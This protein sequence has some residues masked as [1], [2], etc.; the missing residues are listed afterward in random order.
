MSSVAAP[1]LPPLVDHRQNGGQFRSTFSYR[2]WGIISDSSLENVAWILISV[3]LGFHQKATQSFFCCFNNSAGHVCMLVYVS[4]G[5]VKLIIESHSQ[6][7]KC[8][9]ISF[10]FISIWRP[11]NETKDIFL[12]NF[13]LH[14]S[15]SH[16]M[17]DITL[18]QPGKDDHVGTRWQRSR[19]IR[20]MITHDWSPLALAFW[21][22]KIRFMEWPK[23]TRD[24]PNTWISSV[25]EVQTLLCIMEAW[26]WFEVCKSHKSLQSAAIPSSLVPH[27]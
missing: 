24:G 1:V 8:R 2:R 15:M 21:C 10:C 27:S 12:Y 26:I 18:T 23:V 4:N 3:Q 6:V 25:I 16:S 20:M 7:V 13:L 9:Y 5:K 19:R 14:L 17:F 11:V 22:N